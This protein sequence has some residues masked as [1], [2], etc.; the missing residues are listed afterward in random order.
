MKVAAI[1]GGELH[2]LVFVDDFTRMLWVY[3][4]TTKSSAFEVFQ[5]VVAHTECECGECFF[6]LRS[7]NAGEFISSKMQSWCSEGSIILQTTQPYMPDMNGTAERVICTI[8][9]HAS[10]MLWNSFLDLCFWYEAVKTAVY[11]KNRSPH[12]AREKTPF[13]LWTGTFPSLA[14]FVSLVVTVMPSYLIRSDLNGKV[15]VASVCSWDITLLTICFVCL[16]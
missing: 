1:G 13:E 8:V 10:A 9:E 7:D 5:H 3:G 4:L 12:S 6:A 15:M 2:F 14:H 16:T 11:L